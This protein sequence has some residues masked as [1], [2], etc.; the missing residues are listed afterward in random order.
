MRLIYAF[1]ICVFFVAVVVFVVVVVPKLY[2]A[3][4]AI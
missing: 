4:N 1:I 2:F 3:I